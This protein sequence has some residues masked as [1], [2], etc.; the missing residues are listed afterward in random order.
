[1]VNP[2]LRILHVIKGLDRGGAE[3]LLLSTIRN[4][5]VGCRFDVVYFMPDKSMLCDELTAAGAEV[6]CLPVRRMWE[7][8]LAVI[9]LKR[10]LAVTERYDVIHA[11]LPIPGVVARIAGWLAGIPVVYTEHNLVDRYNR[12][13][14]W[15]S[16]LTY[17]MQA[18]TIAVSKAVADSISQEYQPSK[19]IQV[20]YNGVDTSE[21]DPNAHDRKTLVQK[22]E[23]PHKG[24]MVGVI[25]VMTL[26]KRLDR[27]LDLAGQ[28]CRIDSNLQFVL[29]GD[30]PLRHELEAQAAGRIPSGRLRF[31]GVVSQPS[32]W[33][34]CMD[35][36]LLTSDYEGLPVA[37]LEAMSMGC[38][39][40]ASA[41]GGIPDVVRNGENGFLIDPSNMESV[42]AIIRNLAADPLLRRRLGDA[43]RAEVLR[44]YSVNRMVEQ[45]EELYTG[46][47]SNNP[48]A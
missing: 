38:V 46:V 9:R 21:F 24:L 2:E 4:H 36:F 17:G 28:L 34:A 16:K 25:A 31:A 41:V 39:P 33:L 44:S 8:P 12:I 42:T 48:G 7:W 1:M 40:V 43:A 6:V 47:L 10:Y 23:L 30:G 11:H 18:R 15:C 29:V 5:S 3:R 32:E 35:V 22:L 19:P 20:I 14:R 26:Q 27:W 45:L 37:L 13:S